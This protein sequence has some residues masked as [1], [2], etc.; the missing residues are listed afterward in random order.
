MTSERSHDQLVIV[1]SS[2]SFEQACRALEAAIPQQ[3]FGLLGSHD[4]GGTLR[5]KGI[6]FKEKCRIF[7]VCQPQQAAAV[8]ERD[9][10]LN[11]ALPCRLSVYSEAGQ[12][13]IG[14]ISPVAML[15]GLS[16]DAALVATATEVERS[17]RA[18]IE[19]AAEPTA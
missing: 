6:D 15:G 9:M 17:L 12:T 16:S 5:A 14:M 1:S 13:R 3:G 18:I 4:L 10:R 19:S 8:L 7:E 11:M 2:Q